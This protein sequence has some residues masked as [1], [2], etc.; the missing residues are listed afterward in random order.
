MAFDLLL[1]AGVFAEKRLPASDVIIAAPDTHAVNICR[2]QVPVIQ[3]RVNQHLHSQRR[4]QLLI[5]RHKGSACCYSTP[6]AFAPDYDLAFVNPELSCMCVQPLETSIA[7]V[8]WRRMRIFR[9]FAVVDRKDGQSTHLTTRSQRFRKQA[10][11]AT[12]H[13]ATMDLV[14]GRPRL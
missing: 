11:A 2:S 1:A 5:S 13:A 7:V 4:A 6:R 9:R 8:D 12:D 10:R 3:H 14:D